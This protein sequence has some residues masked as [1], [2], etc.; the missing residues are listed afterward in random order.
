MSLGNG[1]WKEGG[2]KNHTESR[3][4]RVSMT[5]PWAATTRYCHTEKTVETK[6]T[7]TQLPSQEG[8]EGW[9]YKT[10]EKLPNSETQMQND[11][12]SEAKL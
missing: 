6:I 5:T 1:A 4:R 3:M 12:T 2:A 10:S 7:T 9:G 11:F 8:W